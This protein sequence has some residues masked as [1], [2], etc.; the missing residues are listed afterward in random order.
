M[1]EGA[2]GLQDEHLGD[3]PVPRR[4]RI[5]LMFSW[6]AV[7]LVLIFTRLLGS[8]GQAYCRE[9]S[10]DDPT[11]GRGHI[12]SAFP[13]WMLIPV[14]LVPVLSASWIIYM[15]PVFP[16]SWMWEIHECVLTI[17]IAFAICRSVVDPGKLYAGR[18]RPDFLYRLNHAG[19]NA[20]YPDP[21][22]T[23]YC[24][25]H[26]HSIESGRHSFPSGHSA[27]S[28]CA[29]SLTALFLMNRL[30]ALAQHEYRA[31]IFAFSVAPLTFAFVVSISRTR[32]NH[33]HFTDIVAG[34]I[35]G[36]LSAVIAFKLQYSFAKA[37]ECFIPTTFL[38]GDIPDIGTGGDDSDDEL[39]KV[40]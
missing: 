35:I 40:G 13:D 25:I 37:R 39:V 31:I 33:H 30:R 34:A 14:G 8:Y 22:A 10:W 1:E 36:L 16:G 21:A 19:Y 17:G 9:F 5:A 15:V 26:T 2:E 20:T 27:V 6:V 4:S 18:L 23:D 11:I 38:R 32:T 28:F 29:M 24:A 3:R 12:P 7:V